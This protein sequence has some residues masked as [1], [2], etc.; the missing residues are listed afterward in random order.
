MSA[1]SIGARRVH[2]NT[3][4]LSGSPDATPSGY[5]SRR[6]FHATVEADA[7]SRPQAAVAPSAT[8][9][10]R[11]SR[12][13]FLAIRIPHIHRRKI[14]DFR[15]LPSYQRTASPTVYPTR[16]GPALFAYRPQSRYATI[17]TRRDRPFPKP[18][19]T[20]GRLYEYAFSH[21]LQ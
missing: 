10:F 18:S 14:I 12:R 2:S 1:S 3:L 11:N 4:W 13:L 8:A 7:K 17:R 6:S 15:F 21:H 9:V 19:A 16:D 20:P 5:R